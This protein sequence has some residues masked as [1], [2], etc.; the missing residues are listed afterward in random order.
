MHIFS[1]LLVC[2]TKLYQHIPSVLV[3]INSHVAV[4][5]VTQLHLVLQLSLTSQVE[6]PPC[7]TMFCLTVY[8]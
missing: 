7:W 2:V 4:C 1:A 8:H 3:M 6:Q 5:Q